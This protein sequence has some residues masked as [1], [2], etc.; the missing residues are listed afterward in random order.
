[1]GIDKQKAKKDKSLELKN[2]YTYMRGECLI[3]DRVPL[4]MIKAA[5]VPYYYLST[6]K[7]LEY[8]EKI[9]NDVREL[10]NKYEIELPIVDTSR[11]NVSLDQEEIVKT[12]KI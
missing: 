1:M 5:G 6:N 8:A 7:S 4:N 12:K 10:M 9:L 2:L 3:K 11:F